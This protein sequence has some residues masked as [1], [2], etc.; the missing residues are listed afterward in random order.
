[1]RF[2][3]IAGAAAVAFL[4]A[5]GPP[6]ADASAA[7]SP[8]P[9]ALGAAAG[10]AVLGGTTVTSAGVST[11]TGDLGVK[12]RDRGDRFPPGDLN[13]TLHAGDAVATQAH[14]D[15]ATAYA[16]AAGRSPAAPI[17]GDLG[18]LTLTP[19]MYAAG[20]ALTLAGTLTPDGRA[21]PMPCS[22]SKPDPRSAQ[23][24]AAR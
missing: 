6:V 18:G 9:V 5:F 11:L 22:S 12:P 20:A 13:G 16:D 2:R 10:F 4:L 23:R 21:T 17:T 7:V 24:P 8:A 15:L 19:G 1:M 3:A 14:A